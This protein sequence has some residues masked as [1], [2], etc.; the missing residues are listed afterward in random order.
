LGRVVIEGGGIA[1]E[2]VRAGGALGE[3]WA[4]LDGGA[5]VAERERGAG[6]QGNQEVSEAAEE[7]VA[8][9]VFFAV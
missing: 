6:V 7:V 2:V 3:G 1:G 9:G 5:A 4:D 8:P